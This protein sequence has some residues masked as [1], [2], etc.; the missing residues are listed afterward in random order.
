MLILFSIFYG[1]D[2]I[3]DLIVSFMVIISTF[4]VVQPIMWNEDESEAATISDRIYY[5][6]I[7][8]LV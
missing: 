5:P 8:V 4:F 6:L 3:P 7:F 2:L 1:V